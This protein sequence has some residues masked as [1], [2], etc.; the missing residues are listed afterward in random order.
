VTSSSVEPLITRKFY[1]LPPLTDYPEHPPKLGRDY[2]IY[3]SSA[4]KILDLG[5]TRSDPLFLNNL[6]EIKK[7]I[8]FTVARELIIIKRFKSP[9]ACRPYAFNVQVITESLPIS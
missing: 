1:F 8:T 7:I 2:R 5:Q 4:I 9:A 3:K 6:K